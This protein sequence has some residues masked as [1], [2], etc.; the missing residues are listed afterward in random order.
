MNKLNRLTGLATVLAAALLVGCGGE[1][2]SVEGSGGGG[3]QSSVTTDLTASDVFAFISNLISGTNENGELVNV[4][5][6]TLAGDDTTA[7]T[8][9]P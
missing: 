6:L 5:V 4:N 2:S 3:E 1:G 8:T 9:L 7:P